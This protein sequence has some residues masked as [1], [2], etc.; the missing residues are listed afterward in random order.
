MKRI[1]PR[2]AVALL[3]I[4]SVGA[5]ACDEESEATAD[6]ANETV[7]ETTKNLTEDTRQAWASLRVDTERLLDQ[8]QTRNDPDAKQRVLSQCR[9][10]E[11]KLRKQDAPNADRVNEFCDKVRTTDP[12]NTSAW[13]DLKQ[14]FNDLS[15]R[16][17]S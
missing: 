14:R 11:E 17:Q 12:T 10:L 9:D 16:F 15:T 8:A 3:L 5:I 1:L 6:R 2:L 4:A 13:D 7:K